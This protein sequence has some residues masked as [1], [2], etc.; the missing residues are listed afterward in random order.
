MNY[1]WLLLTGLWVLCSCTSSNGT[2]SALK[3]L[4]AEVL[5][6]DAYCGNAAFRPAVTW[7]ATPL[8][9]VRLYA[10][11]NSQQVSVTPPA[12]DFSDAGV[13]FIAMGQQPTAGYALDFA[14]GTVRQRQETLDITVNWQ[15]P[16]AGYLLAQVVTAPCLLLKVPAV[17]VQEFRVLDQ[18]G[19]VRLTGAP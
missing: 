1:R 16:P 5:Y 14:Q 11:F 17:A 10:G 13:L 18:S 6:T 4:E 7:I 3:S 19:Q 15:E 8:E 12:V 9:L 2:G